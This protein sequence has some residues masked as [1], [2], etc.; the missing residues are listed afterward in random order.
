MNFKEFE[1]L[2]WK[3]L[4]EEAGKIRRAFVMLVKSIFKRKVRK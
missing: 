2:Y 4:V 1:K 3:T